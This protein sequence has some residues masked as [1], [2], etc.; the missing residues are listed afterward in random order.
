MEQEN[1][2]TQ[3]RESLQILTRH[4]GLFSD[5]ARPVKLNVEPGG[6]TLS[7]T[8][9]LK[10]GPGGLK[11]IHDSARI[12][13]KNNQTA[14]YILRF[15][16]KDSPAY[17]NLVEGIVRKDCEFRTLEARLQL[18]QTAPDQWYSQF[19]AEKRSGLEREFQE[20]EGEFLTVWQK[21]KSCE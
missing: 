18:V 4:E 12:H 19:L 15:V 16:D 20:M 5:E 13:T 3:F 9:Q 11:I 10:A 2:Y 21:C 7:V 6:T 14:G 8:V 1:S 17:I